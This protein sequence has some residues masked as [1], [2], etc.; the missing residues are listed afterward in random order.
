A[1]LAL[2]AQHHVGCTSD[3]RA[4]PE[5]VGQVHQ[6]GTLRYFLL[7]RVFS[8]SPA[9]NL[10]PSVSHENFPCCLARYQGGGDRVGVLRFIEQDYIKGQYGIAQLEQLEIGIRS[11]E[12]RVGKESS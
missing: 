8:A 3:H 10:L 9:I 11:E 12:R 6:I 1:L 5:R 7:Q 4:E 2:E